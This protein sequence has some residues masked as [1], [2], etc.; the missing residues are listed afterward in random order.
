MI[1]IPSKHIPLLKKKEKKL[2]NVKF[3]ILYYILKYIFMI[4]IGIYLTKFQ[5]KYELIS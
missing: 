2:L 5:E 1:K 3:Y 4:I